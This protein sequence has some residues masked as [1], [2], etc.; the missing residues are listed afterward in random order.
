METPGESSE[1][2]RSYNKEAVYCFPSLCIG[3][4]LRLLSDAEFIEDHS[5]ER[6][7]NE[8]YDALENVF[9]LFESNGISASK[10]F[11]NDDADL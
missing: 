9:T 2:V 8:I 11:A 4:A 10:Q 6:R 7:L 1:A 3:H 5:T